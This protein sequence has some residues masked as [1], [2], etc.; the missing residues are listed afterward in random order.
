MVQYYRYIW[1][2][3]SHKLDPLEELDSGPKGRKVLWNDLIEY[4][5]IEIKHMVSADI[6]FSYP[7][8]EIC[9]TVHTDASDKNLS[10][11]ISQNNKPISF[12][13]R[14]LSKPENTYTMSKKEILTIFQCPNQFRVIIFFYE[15]NVF[16]YH[17]IW[18]IP[19][20]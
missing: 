14:R 9:F 6:F 13:S 5:F 1:P 17:K 19:Q 8:W 20:P 4:S 16:S 10:A 12:F 15:I 11:Y 7:D 3:Q 2:R 18:Y